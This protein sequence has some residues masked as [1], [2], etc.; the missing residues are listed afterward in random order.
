MTCKLPSPGRFSLRSDRPP[1]PASAGLSHLGEEVEQV[2]VLPSCTF[3]FSANRG[4]VGVGVEDVESETADHGEICRA[5][6]LAGTGAIFIEHDVEDPVQTVLDTPVS[7]HDTQQL[8]GRE[9]L[10]EQKES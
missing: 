9:A 4:F 3:H 10:R 7:A 2:C 5:I 6:V 1:S 8:L